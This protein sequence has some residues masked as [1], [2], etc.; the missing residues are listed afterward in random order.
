MFWYYNYLDLNVLGPDQ[1][2][3]QGT[4]SLYICFFS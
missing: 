2:K 3:P 4:C 1:K